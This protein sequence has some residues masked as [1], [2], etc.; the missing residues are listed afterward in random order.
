M[1]YVRVPEV[2]DRRLVFY[3]AMEEYLA[4]YTDGESFFIW[5]VPPTVI[6][7]RNQALEAEADLEYCRDRGIQVWRRK[8][9][10]GCVYADEGNIMVSRIMGGHDV[11]F[12]FESHLLRLALFLRRIGLDAAV[13]GRNDILVDG[14]KVSGNAFYSMHGRNVVHGTLLFDA[15]CDVMERVL[16]PSKVKLERNGVRS[17]RQRVTN[18]KDVMTRHGIDGR[19]LDMDFFIRSLAG[20]FC[21]GEYVL[22][23]NE[24]RMIEEIEADYL[25]PDFISG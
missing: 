2:R 7:G 6:V 19:Y 16:T 14:K 3:L 5:R 8:S 20:Y 12:L 22:G 17:V 15:D 24:I 4:R 13:S 1:R 11:P 18:L 23:E 9:G 10:G 21:D 25:D